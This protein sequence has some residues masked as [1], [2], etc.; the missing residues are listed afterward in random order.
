MPRIFDNIEADLLPALEQSLDL[1]HRTDFCVGYFNLR[2]WK[3]LDTRIE[4][5]S[6]GDLPQTNDVC[7]WST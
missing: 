6:G 3:E 5:W 7:I 4:N 1:S 2:D